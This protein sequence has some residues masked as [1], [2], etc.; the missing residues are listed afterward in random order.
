MCITH[1]DGTP[2]WSRGGRVK[3][4]HVEVGDDAKGAL[5]RTAEDL[6]K[7]ADLLRERASS[8]QEKADQHRANAKAKDD[9]AA[10]LEAAAAKL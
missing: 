2:I 6:K 9:Q 10:E 1:A 8:D 4:L 3:D 7:A 5:L